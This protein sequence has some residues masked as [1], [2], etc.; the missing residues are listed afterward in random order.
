MIICVY[1]DE[2][3]REAREVIAQ[4]GIQ[5]VRGQLAGG[6]LGAGGGQAAVLA[7]AGAHGELAH[8]RRA[9]VA[10]ELVLHAR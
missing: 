8:V 1:L 6:L 10:Y 2:I 4:V 7:E 3:G 5:L 9:S